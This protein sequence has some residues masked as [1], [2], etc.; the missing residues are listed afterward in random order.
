LI[1]VRCGWSVD[2]DGTLHSITILWTLTVSS[3]YLQM[4][5]GC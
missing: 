4:S 5:S 2:D 3:A 1:V